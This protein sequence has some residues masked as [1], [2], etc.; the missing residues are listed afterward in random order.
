MEILKYLI[1]RIISFLGVILFGITLVFFITR[2]SPI[3][4]VQNY[5]NAIM[6][7]QGGGI[8]GEAIEE[9]RVNLTILD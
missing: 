1:F 7:G 6:S 5:L 9:M 3:D 2:L 8:D 4:P